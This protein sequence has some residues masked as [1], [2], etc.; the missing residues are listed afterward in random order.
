MNRRKKTSLKGKLNFTTINSDEYKNKNYLSARK[1]SSSKLTQIEINT[2]TMNNQEENDEHKKNVIS[3]IKMTRACV[4][5]Y[6]CF[7]R[8][9]KIVQNFLLDEGMGIICEKLDI[10]NIFEKMY[11]DEE[12]MEK[13]VSNNQI[14]MSGK[15]KLKLR[16]I[17]N[18]I[19]KF[20]KY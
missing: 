15:C 4:Y 12:I 16:S 20:E 13:I 2:S 19:T 7:T 6:F 17:Y 5:L 8:R 1:K 10:F 14:E 3:K 11:K 18:K 9:R